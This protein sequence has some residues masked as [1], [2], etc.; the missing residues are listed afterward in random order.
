MCIKSKETSQE[1]RTRVDI[2]DLQ[3]YPSFDKLT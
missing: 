1:Y 3:V 2:E